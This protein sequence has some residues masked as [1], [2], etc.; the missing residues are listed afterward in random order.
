MNAARPK[1]PRPI[2]KAVTH[3]IPIAIFDEA[4]MSETPS[5]PHP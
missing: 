5:T 3:T 4:V 2:P 1:P